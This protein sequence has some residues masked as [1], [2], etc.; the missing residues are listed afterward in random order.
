MRKWILAAVLVA[1]PVSALQAM[2]V[3][4]FLQKAEALQA[5]GALALLSS[6][7]TL[8]KNEVA[9]AGQSLRAERLAARRAGR[10]PAYCPPENSSFTPDELL[11]GFRSIPAAQR[12]R[13]QVRDGLRRLL[14]RRY[15]CRG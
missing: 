4:T 8:L 15:P 7:F 12:Q 1:L 3:A 9:A 5:R 6:D 14:I 10:R 11:A 13:M 2:T